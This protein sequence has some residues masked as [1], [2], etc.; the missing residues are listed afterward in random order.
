MRGCVYSYAW[1]KAVLYRSGLVRP[2][3]PL[4]PR[5]KKRERRPLLGMMLFQDGS[6]HEWFAG[7]PV[8]D[9]IVTMDDATSEIFSMFFVEQ[10]GAASTS[11]W[12]RETIGAKG[13]FSSF[14]QRRRSS[15][16]PPRPFGAR[17]PCAPSSARRRAPAAREC[18]PNAC[19][20]G[21]TPPPLTIAPRPMP[22][23]MAGLTP[24]PRTRP[25]RSTM[26]TSIT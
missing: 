13:L 25:T 9:L 19:A 21:R 4:G 14:Y 3:R 7:K 2:K 23:S 26:I 22:C 12:L 18:W 15:R 8:V 5:R 17:S 11:R 6:T 20:A 16:Q 24:M 10:E 1:T